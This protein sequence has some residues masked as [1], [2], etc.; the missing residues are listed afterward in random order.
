MNNVTESI[1]NSGARNTV[2]QFINASR[3][4]VVKAKSIAGDSG[5]L[6]RMVNDVVE[7]WRAAEQSD[8]EYAAYRACLAAEHHYNNIEGLKSGRIKI[9]DLM[10]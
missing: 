6:N 4:F 10:R 7:S 2:E 1:L 8:C 9:S 3:E 5:F